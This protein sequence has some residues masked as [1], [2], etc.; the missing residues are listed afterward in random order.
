M[1]YMYYYLMMDRL[2]F[3]KKYSISEVTKDDS[4]ISKDIRLLN[5][6]EE[7]LK[8]GNIEECHVLA[9]QLSQEM[10]NKMG[11]FIEQ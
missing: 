1:Y 10:R 4:T 6:I 5:Y 2:T 8:E 9:T 11:D 7:S 3:Q